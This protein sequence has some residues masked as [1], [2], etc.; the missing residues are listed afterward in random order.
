MSNFNESDFIY[1]PIEEESKPLQS[2]FGVKFC[3]DIFLLE[4]FLKQRKIQYNEEDLENTPMGR[5][6]RIKKG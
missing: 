2:T 5:A 6:I 1:K 4:S 3:N